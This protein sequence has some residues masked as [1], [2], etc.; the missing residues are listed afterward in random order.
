[1]GK[2]NDIS[3]AHKEAWIGMSMNVDFSKGGYQ[4]DII[5]ETFKQFTVR[6]MPFWWHFR[7]VLRASHLASPHW[8]KADGS[9]LSGDEQK[10]LV[11]L[12]LMN[13][14]VYTGIAESLAFFEQL[15]FQVFRT[16]FDPWRIFDARR[17]WK[18]TYSSLYSSFNALCN[19]VCIVV[20]H[21][22]PFGEKPGKVW[23][24]S[25]SSAYRLVNGKGIV[26][27]SEP[28]KRVTE[29]LEI[30]SQLDHYW[31]IWH[32]IVQGKFLIDKNFTK[33][34]VPLDIGADV[35]LKVD[36]IGLAQEHLIK[37]VEDFNVVYRELSVAGGFLDQYVSARGWAV[38]YSDY[39]EPHNGQRPKP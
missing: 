11:A 28:L 23:N 24:Y 32:G 38:D 2:G 17:Y 19:I 33:G 22:P 20:G 8:A 13:Y 4:G 21:K 6:S 16:T 9:A 29:R 31:L 18:A 34:Y 7:E 30:R 27:I 39:G 37:S 10:E 12:S 14:A 25:P 35:S 1:M 26:S 36:A 3:R 5:E 15:Q